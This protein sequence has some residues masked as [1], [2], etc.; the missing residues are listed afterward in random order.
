QPPEH[1]A[2]RRAQWQCHEPI[3][4]PG[5]HTVQHAARDPARPEA[6]LVRSRST[7]TLAA[8]LLFGATWTKTVAPGEQTQAKPEWDLVVYGGP[9][10]WYLEPH[11]AEAVFGD[12]VREAG[13]Q[14]FLQ[15]RLRETSGVIR[16]G[17]RIEAISVENGESFR[18][19]IFADASYEGDLMAQAGVGYTW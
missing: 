14:V 6:L 19:R 9:V 10:T 13:V 8:L 1:A 15:H 4:R 12:M 2:L 11:V 7:S 5:D 17:T 3:V 16:R 18:A